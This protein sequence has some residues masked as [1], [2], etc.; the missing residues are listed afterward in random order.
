MCH[1]P[2]QFV[3]GF[4]SLMATKYLLLIKLKGTKFSTKHIRVLIF[5]ITE[6]EKLHNNKENVVNISGQK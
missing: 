5:I 6:L 1:T 3:Y 4:H 2:F